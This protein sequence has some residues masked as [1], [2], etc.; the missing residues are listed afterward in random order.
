MC[1]QVV[2]GWIQENQ[3]VERLLRTGLH[4]KQYMEQV[5][6]RPQFVRVDA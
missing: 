6:G 5:G 4:H 2:Y 1:L 3:I